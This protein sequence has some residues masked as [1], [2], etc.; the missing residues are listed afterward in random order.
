M[1]FG[2]Q[3]AELD[4]AGLTGPTDR[5]PSVSSLIKEKKLQ[6]AD[7]RFWNAD[8]GFKVFCP[9]KTIERSDSTIRHSSIVIRHF[10]NAWMWLN[11]TYNMQRGPGSIRLLLGSFTRTRPPAK[12][13]PV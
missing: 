8:F 11:P 13:Q 5:W 10:M 9:F 4:I 3:G 2:V 6:K 7:F 12:G 1:R